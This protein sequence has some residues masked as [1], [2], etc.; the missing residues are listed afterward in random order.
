M[1]NGQRP[2]LLFV[3]GWGFDASMWQQLRAC[4]APE[5]TLAWDL[6]FFGTPDQP[7]PPPGR[8]VLCGVTSPHQAAP[9]TATLSAGLEALQ[10]W[11]ERPAEVA[12]ALCGAGD[13]LV[14][15]A[16]SRACFPEA[17]FHWHEAGHMLP[18]TAAAWCAG[19]LRALSENLT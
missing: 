13:R 14:S 5:D 1:R 3:H 17:M 19:H 12:A 4:F 9:A 18:L 11:D 15:P 8:L 6:G 7:L 2:L 10:D 16:M